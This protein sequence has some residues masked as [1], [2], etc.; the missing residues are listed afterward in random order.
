MN[1]LLRIILII[2]LQIVLVL[3]S[4]LVI[5]TKRIEGIVTASTVLIAEI[6]RDKQYEALGEIHN[7]DIILGDK[8]AKVTIVMYTRFDCIHCIDFFNETFPQIYSEYIQPGY[9]SFTVRYFTGVNHEHIP[10]TQLAYEAYSQ[11]K[12]LEFS[13]LLTDANCVF[14]NEKIQ[15]IEDSLGIKPKG[16]LDLIESNFKQAVDSGIKSTPTF[17]INGKKYSGNK[18]IKL[19]KNIIDSQ[20]SICD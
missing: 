5:R 12:Y 20:Y 16:H 18:R 7:N 11:N 9:A 19:F 3:T 13:K 15:L 14:D 1:K 10:F 17:I 6:F 4:I 2:E 8:N